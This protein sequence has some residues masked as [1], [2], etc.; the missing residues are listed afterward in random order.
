MKRGVQ[1]LSLTVSLK[2]IKNNVQSSSLS[3]TAPMTQSTSSLQTQYLPIGPCRMAKRISCKIY[4]GL[5]KKR[6]L[7]QV[8]CSSKQEFHIYLFCGYDSFNRTDSVCYHQ[9]G[10]S[11]SVCKTNRMAFF[12]HIV[13][14]KMSKRCF[15][16]RYTYNP[17][18][19][20][21]GNLSKHL[22]IFRF[23]DKI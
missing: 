15:A 22:S 9:Y 8:G 2:S 1:I 13:L 19:F 21:E 7:Q 5:Q 6:Q 23:L 17:R 18:K 3:V 20:I 12:S 4:S 10:S 14:L 11:A 16:L